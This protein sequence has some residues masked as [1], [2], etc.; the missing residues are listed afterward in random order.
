VSDSA[1]PELAASGLTADDLAF[2]FVTSRVGLALTAT[3]GERWRR[4]VERLRSPEDIGQWSV[5]AGLLA[6]PAGFSAAD[7]DAVRQLREVIYGS[8]LALIAGKRVGIDARRALNDA[9][10]QPSLVPRLDGETTTWVT[11]PHPGTALLSSLARDAIDVF[12]GEDARR[13]R[14]CA[15]PTCALIFLDT[16]RPGRRRWCS[17]T[18]CGGAAR[19][20]AYR[21]RHGP[22]DHESRQPAVT[23]PTIAS[24][25]D[26]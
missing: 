7:L 4:G 11:G 16:S 19:A 18:G 17:S 3:V 8:A 9:A 10:A 1:R 20:A 12:G 24:F 21:R 13:L 22:T 2:R 25:R 14:A 26:L 23:Q 6:T 15:S 5:A